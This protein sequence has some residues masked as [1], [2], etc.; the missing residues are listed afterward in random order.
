M[1][2]SGEY[3]Y[4][5]VDGQADDALATLRFPEIMVKPNEEMCFS[6]GYHMYGQDIGRLKVVREDV[7]GR[8]SDL[9][10]ESGKRCTP[11]DQTCSLRVVELR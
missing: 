7:D 6:F 8:R 10:S 1:F 11:H 9:F 5:E 3:L 2:L 4:I